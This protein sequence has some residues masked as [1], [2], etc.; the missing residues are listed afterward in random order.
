ML[1]DAADAGE[2]PNRALREPR[3]GATSRENPFA[4]PIRGPRWCGHVL[5]AATERSSQGLASAMASRH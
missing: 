3:R 1:V 4:V 5:A 2:L